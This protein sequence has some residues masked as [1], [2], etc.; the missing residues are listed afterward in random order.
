M[1][2]SITYADETVEA[3]L[4]KLLTQKEAEA[5]VKDRRAKKEAAETAHRNAALAQSATEVR[6]VNK[7]AQKIV[8]RK[9]ALAPRSEATVPSK[10]LV[11][12]TEATASLEIPT[13]YLHESI[14]L[15]ASVYGDEYSK[16]KWRDTTNG[17][18]VT[19][20]TNISLNFLKP[21][22]S[23]SYEGVQ[24]DYFGFVTSYTQEDEAARIQFAQEQG[25]H[26]ESHWEYPPVSFS[27]DY[28]EYFVDAPWDA[29]IPEKLYRQLNALFNFYLE[30]EERFRI[31]YLNTKTLQAAHE[32]DLKANPPQ[33][34]K[35]V[36]MNYTPLRGK[37]AE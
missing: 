34:A 3:D 14:S 33:K 11:A 15:G 26:A 37:A 17:Q 32:A 1:T 12:N 21:I 8:F 9:V 10:E 23:F 5:I 31:E 36:I 20:W 24:Y 18:T 13:E 28:Y 27:S 4:P 19:V 2:V 16:I 22:V 25:H 30:G 35:Q 29:E 7:G 6:V